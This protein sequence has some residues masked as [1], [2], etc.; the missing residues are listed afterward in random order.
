M[1]DTKSLCLLGVKILSA[2]AIGTAVVLGIDKLSG[3]KNNNQQQTPPP[4]CNNDGMNGG[5]LF[6]PQGQQQPQGQQD[7]FGNSGNSTCDSI[8]EGLRTTQNICKGV[9]SVGVAIGGV[10]QCIGQLSNCINGRQQPQFN[11]N[12]NSGNVIFGGYYNRGYINQPDQQPQFQGYR[13][14]DGEE[15]TLVRRSNYVLSCVPK[16]QAANFQQF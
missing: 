9:I 10:V 11:N 14:Q 3:N 1:L 6:A 12:M 15:L 7:N 13:R 5:G 8:L 16:S 2:V 4:P